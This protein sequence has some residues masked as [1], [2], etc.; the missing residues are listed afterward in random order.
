MTVGMLDTGS[1]DIGSIGIW[2][3]T[4]Y[5]G[6]PFAEEAE[7]LA[8]VDEQGWGAVWLPEHYGRES[9]AHSALALGATRRIPVVPG[10]ANLWAR[11]PVAMVN[12]GRTL[13]EAHPNRFAI[14]LGVSH[15]PVIESRGASADRS[16]LDVVSRYLDEM[17]RAK[18]TAASPAEEPPR[19]LAALGPR[20]LQLAATRTA[21]AHTYTVPVEHT[22]LAREVMGPDAVLAVEQKVVLSDDPDTSRAVARQF[23]PL[24][25][26]NY[27]NNLL[28]CGFE[29][30]DLD[31]GGT[32]DVVDRLV[33]WGDVAS[34][35]TRVKE[36]LA[37]GADHVCLQVLP[38]DGRL[39]RRE[40][41]E[42]ADA[43]IGET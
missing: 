17:D 28:R 8:E 7:A 9:M 29:A 3:S 19:I 34:I 35:Q 21:G 40:W 43:L 12:G 10:I 20:M 37:A 36:H 13:A 32:A 4:A 27:R 22:A 33:A 26:P 2:W 16:P 39:P 11:D 5:D 14:G 18:Y 24:F 15:R 6:A 31:D 41:R 23:L 30:A 1:I 25:L 42:L 38:L